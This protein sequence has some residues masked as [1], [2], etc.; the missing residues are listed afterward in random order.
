MIVHVKK[1]SLVLRVVVDGLLC[2]AFVLVPLLAS[3]SGRPATGVVK[4]AGTT[5][6]SIGTL[7]DSKAEF[8]G[9][10]GTF[11]VGT[12]PT[13]AFPARLSGGGTVETIQ[14][15]LASASG[16][17]FLNV[18]AAD[19]AQN[20]TSGM[21]ATINGVP[22]TP[23][24]AGSW[25]FSK[26]GNGGRNQGVQTLRW[27]LP[28][29]ALV[30]GQNTLLLRV[31][32]APNAGPGS[33]PDGVV[34]YFDMD[35]VSLEQGSLNLALPKR[36]VGSTDYWTN[37]ALVNRM[38]ANAA[39]FSNGQVWINYLLNRNVLDS[40]IEIVEEMHWTASYPDLT[41]EDVHLGVGQWDEAAWAYYRYY[42][43]QL[44][45]AGV[46]RIL[47]KL[48]YTPRWASTMPNS[49]NYAA[50]APT[51]DAY[52][53][54]FIHEVAVRLGDVVDDYAIMN[55]VTMTGFWAD[56]QEAYYRLERLAYDTLKQYDTVDAN[57]DGVA[58]F[59]AP[60]SSNEPGQTDQW[61]TWYTALYPKMDAFHTHDYKWGLKPSADIIQA[62]DPNLQYLI[63]ETGPANWFI[64]QDA[65]PEY[66]PAEAA[67]AI[68]YLLKDPTSPIDFLTQ[69]VLK[70]DPDK[71]APWPD[72]NEWYNSE[73]D[74][75]AN[76]DGYI[77]TFNTGIVNIEP[78]GPPYTNWAFNSA[79][80][81]WQHWGW[82]L[83]WN[84]NQV[85]VEMVG[86]GDWQYE[87]DAVNMG[88]RIEVIVTDFQG[89]IIPAPHTIGLQVT[90]PWTSVKVDS[91]EPD[92]LT[93]TSTT[94]GPVVS[95]SAA[96]L[97][98]DSVRFVL[99]NAAAPNNAVP[100]VFIASPAKS[101]TVS[102]NV[103][104]AADAYDDGSIAAVEYR[105]DPIN[106]GT[107]SPLALQSGSRYTASW[108]S[109]SVADGDHTIQVRVRDS[110][111]K[112]STVSH[113]V[114]VSNGG[115]PTGAMHVSNIA[116]AFQKS[117]QTY[118]AKATVT[119]VDANN[120]AVSGAT[121][122][123]TFSG[124]TSDSVSGTTDAS[125]NVTL[126]SSGKKGGGTWTFCVTDVTKSG[127]TYNASANVETC[128]TITAP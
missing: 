116:M 103:T 66:N 70:G 53:T 10:V 43:Q 81:Y 78:P 46:Q 105:I 67:S 9:S 87:V 14:F 34:P 63:S 68:G 73:P 94:A 118:K 7:D 104:I 27:A 25:E 84:G 4:A 75:Y 62:I 51:N 120:A 71:N 79:G 11:I 86:N 121:V 77:E 76:N 40:D 115:G 57:G 5:V 30:V 126:T 54:E 80:A 108:N 38:K 15:T 1:R 100:G 117:G 33:A 128:D 93:G 17:H 45:A 39:A 95:L 37:T 41:W 107:F 123:G 19:T 113:V 83:D 109:A 12:S 58:C 47:I 26:W 85:P 106:A 61:Q 31:S 99:S 32:A 18:V 60:S 114:K 64:N 21:Q 59:V 111:G 65:V 50:Y 56:T 101:A 52:W 29:S 89:G 23:R 35:Y 97:A 110:T 3:R 13:S 122:S 124:A 42:Y 2:L 69:W 6:W 119:I 20:S 55:E 90:T 98:L 44:R 8:A 82:V 49:S 88:D 127:W 74:P 112:S 16:D 125:G 72:P 28:T 102:G 91:Y 92:D 48:Q 22:L 36:Y 96:N 24:W